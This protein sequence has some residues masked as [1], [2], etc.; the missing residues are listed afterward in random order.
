MQLVCGSPGGWPSTD[1]CSDEVLDTAVNLPLSKRS[2]HA[3]RG[4]VSLKLCGVSSAHAE[5]HTPVVSGV[6]S[7][8]HT[9]GRARAHSTLHI[10]QQVTC[11]RACRAV[12]SSP[13]A[14]PA[15]AELAR[16]AALTRSLASEGLTPCSTSPVS[17]PGLYVFLQRDC[18]LAEQACF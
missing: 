15:V 5:T 3:C 9:G 10:C 11:H 7:A 12:H 18:T 1:M 8:V 2:S 13:E 16:P 4:D 14:L 6:C 17:S